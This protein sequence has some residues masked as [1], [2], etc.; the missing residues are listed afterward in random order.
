MKITVSR[1]PHDVALA[2]ALSSG[3]EQQHAV[4]VPD[5]PARFLRV[6]SAREEDD[7]GEG[8]VN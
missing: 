6:A 1:P 7:G 2:P 4:P 5:Q 8:G 3:V